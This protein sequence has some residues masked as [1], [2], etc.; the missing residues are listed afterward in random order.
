MR[1]GASNRKGTALRNLTPMARLE[2]LVG[3]TPMTEKVEKGPRFIPLYRAL[4]IGRDTEFMFVQKHGALLE[5][6]VVRSE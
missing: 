5:I 6:M 2:A 3:I 4:V 1:P